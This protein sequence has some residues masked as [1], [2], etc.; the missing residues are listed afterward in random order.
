MFVVGRV[1]GDVG[2]TMRG[3]GGY[4]I[5]MKA[6]EDKPVSYDDQSFYIRRCGRKKNG[7]TSV[8]GRVGERKR[9][10]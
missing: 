5:R 8:A 1:T 10:I 6:A 9:D 7:K 4:E 3:L 2:I